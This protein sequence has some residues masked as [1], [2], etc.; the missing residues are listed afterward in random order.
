MLMIVA[1]RQ[2]VINVYNYNKFI[3]KEI[4]FYLAALESDLFLS[5]VISASYSFTLIPRGL[6][7]FGDMKISNPVVD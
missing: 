1:R 4:I 5:S 7:K 6:L 3:C 2:A